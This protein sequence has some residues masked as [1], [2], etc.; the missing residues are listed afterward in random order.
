MTSMLRGRGESPP[1]VEDAPPIDEAPAD[2]CDEEAAEDWYSSCGSR[3]SQGYPVAM[4]HVSVPMGEISVNAWRRSVPREVADWDDQPPWSDNKPSITCTEDSYFSEMH[5]TF[6]SVPPLVEYDKGFVTDF[7]HFWKSP[8]S[9]NDS[10]FEARYQWE[11]DTAGHNSEKDLDFPDEESRATSPEVEAPGE[12]GGR[13]SRAATP[14]PCDAASEGRGPRPGPDKRRTKGN[15]LRLFVSLFTKC[16][17]PAVPN[18]GQAAVAAAAAQSDDY[19]SEG[20]EGDERHRDV[21]AT[22]DSMGTL[23]SMKADLHEKFEEGFRLRQMSATQKKDSGDVLADDPPVSQ[24]RSCS[25]ASGAD[26]AYDGDIS[27]VSFAEAQADCMERSWDAGA[28]EQAR[29]CGRPPRRSGFGIEEDSDGS[30]G[31][32]EIF[33]SFSA[34]EAHVHQLEMVDLE[35]KD[36]ASA[37]ETVEDNFIFDTVTTGD[38]EMEDVHW[39][40]MDGA[41]RGRCQWGIVAH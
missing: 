18:L 35:L 27:E 16:W 9:I 20:A 29:S 4:E 5:S 26:L 32:D 2:S 24:S 10:M 8:R 33:A 15:P 41:G 25:P 12:A 14:D 7:G 30:V 40:W 3:C 21:Q 17:R 28:A 36:M 19:F 1:S 39:P 22:I 38:A 23:G 11:R 13:V 37:V 34:V 6:S 31:A